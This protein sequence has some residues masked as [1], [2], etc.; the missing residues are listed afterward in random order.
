MDD[1]FVLWTLPTNKTT[2]A[3][4]ETAKTR[5][6]KINLSNLRISLDKTLVEDKVF[7]YYYNNL[8]WQ[9]YK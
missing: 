3:A 9:T 1:D 7:N 8:S 2:P 6:Y 5:K 4:G